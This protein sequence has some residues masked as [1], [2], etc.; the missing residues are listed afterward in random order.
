ML[1]TSNQQILSTVPIKLENT[2]V[3]SPETLI[4]EISNLDASVTAIYILYPEHEHLLPY[5][6]NF[7]VYALGKNLN[8]LDEIGSAI[9]SGAEDYLDRRGYLLERN[10]NGEIPNAEAENE[11]IRL[12]PKNKNLLEGG[13]PQPESV[14][15]NE[16]PMTQ[17]KTINAIEEPKIQS[18]ITDTINYARLEELHIKPTG[19]RQVIAVTSNKGGIGKTTVSMSI[20]QLLHETNKGRTIIVDAMSP[21]GNVLTRMGFKAEINLKSWESYMQNG[22]QLTD[23]QILQN[24]VIKHPDG[25]YVLPCIPFGYECSVD[26]MNYVLTSLARVFDFVVIDIGVERHELLSAAM[27]I[28]NKTLLVVDYDIA[29]LKDSRDYIN[30][31]QLRQL[32]LDKL[33]VIVNMEPMRKEKNVINRKKCKETLSDLRIIG[34][35]PEVIGMR[36]I[37]NKGKL[38]VQTDPNN[39]F[40]Q[41]MIKIMEEIIPDYKLDNKKKGLW[42]IFFGKRH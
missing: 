23:K 10:F 27:I 2:K 6:R 39:P 41:E 20:A 14:Q 16:R 31:W 32:D 22:V 15:N 8:D 40:S 12:R 37:H 13:M 4:R 17:I 42:E 21:H 33:Q 19:G 5:L 28:A 9:Q 24:L 35:L 29:T 7:K 34:Y 3:V 38:M 1:L 30:S 26:L 18:N 25:I 11:T 36:A